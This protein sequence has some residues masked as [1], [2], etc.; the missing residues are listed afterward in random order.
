MHVMHVIDSMHGGGAETSLLEILPGLASRGVRR[1][2]S[3][4]GLT[5]ASSKTDSMPSDVRHIRLERRD[6][7]GMTIELRNSS[8]PS[9]PISFT[10]HCCSRIWRAGSRRGLPAPRSSPP[11]PIRITGRS[12]G[13]TLAMAPGAYAGFSR[14]PVTAPLTTRFH[15]ISADVARVMSRRLRIPRDRIQVV[16]RGRDPPA[17]CSRSSGGCGRGPPC[18][19]SKRRWS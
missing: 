12:T 16:Y 17:G 1:P 19:S 4:C 5:T 9:A 15:A 3:R 6:P 10:R 14:R 2:L 18:R 8:A 7:L 11:W 13:R